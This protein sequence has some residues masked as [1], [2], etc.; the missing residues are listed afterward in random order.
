MAT[1]SN[2]KCATSNTTNYMQ[3]STWSGI[4]DTN[5]WVLYIFKN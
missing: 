4:T 2:H 1:L 5:G 3:R